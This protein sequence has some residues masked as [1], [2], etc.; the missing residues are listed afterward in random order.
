MDWTALLEDHNIHYVSRGPN[1]R[2]G[3]VSVKCPWCGDDDPS[4]HLGISL[5]RE[6]WGCHRDAQHRGK[7]PHRLIQALLG[8]SLA[9]AKLVV[10]QYGAA[11]PEALDTVLS[12]PE[13]A[14]AVTGP[15]EMPDEFASITAEGP[16]K[17]FY[18]YLIYR[19]FPEPEELIE[20]YQLKCCTTGRWKD[21]IIIPVYR[22]GELLAW[23]GRALQN[24]ITAPRY[25]STS[26]AIK[27][28]IFNE[29]ALA[30]GGEILFVTEGPFDAIKVD[31]YGHKSGALATAT[32]GTSIT[33]DQIKAIRNAQKGFEKTVLLFD[34]DAIETAFNIIEWLPKAIIGTLPD[35]VS[36]PGDLSQSQVKALIASY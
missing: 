3:E 17:R 30:K 16:T 2:R 10:A 27:T 5:E 1:T 33:P 13:A 25:L 23:T 19:G 21:R 6:A 32:F 36:D 22:N 11:D 4:E 26:E 15:I 18:W 35:R 29:D 12:S 34:A 8:C 24:P 9:Q 14:K 31:F 28:V 20:R 7:N